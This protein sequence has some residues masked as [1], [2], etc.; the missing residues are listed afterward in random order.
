MFLPILVLK[1]QKLQVVLKFKSRNINDS[2]VYYSLKKLKTLPP[3]LRE[4]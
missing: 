1:K 4:F 2:E 3:Y